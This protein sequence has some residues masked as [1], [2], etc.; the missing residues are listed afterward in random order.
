MWKREKLQFIVEDLKIL[1]I[2][3]IS[4]CWWMN[5]KHLLINLIIEKSYRQL[6]KWKK[7][8]IAS[9]GRN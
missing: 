7:V 8:S 5:I 9:S 3:F 6:T 2:Y 4:H 1:K